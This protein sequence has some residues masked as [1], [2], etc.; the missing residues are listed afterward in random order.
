MSTKELHNEF[1]HEYIS[2]IL[3]ELTKVKKWVTMVVNLNGN[4]MKR[5]CYFETAF[6][7]EYASGNHKLCGHYFNFSRNISK[8]QRECDVSHVNRDKIN[9]VCQ[10]NVED[11]N[12]NDNFIQ[13][14]DAIKRKEY[15][16]NKRLR[17]KKNIR[18]N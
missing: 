18:M 1:Y 8:K 2:Y 3:G 4:V 17:L 6:Y 7:I 9:C 5:T 13:I 15:I 10:L 14:V 12:V 16:K 11:N